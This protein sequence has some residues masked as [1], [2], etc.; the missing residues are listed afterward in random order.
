MEH[1]H[2]TVYISEKL[3]LEARSTVR[4]GFRFI[5]FFACFTFG[6]RAKSLRI[7]SETHDLKFGTRCLSWT[8]L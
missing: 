1:P 6:H 4:N 7:H 3:A 5:L 2:F 8:Q